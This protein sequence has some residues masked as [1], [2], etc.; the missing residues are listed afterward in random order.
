M[1]QLCIQIFFLVHI[2]T[3][4]YDICRV[5]LKDYLRSISFC[6]KNHKMTIFFF[7]LFTSFFLRFQRVHTCFCL[8]VTTRNTCLVFEFSNLV[9]ISFLFQCLFPD[10]DIFFNVAILN[11]IVAEF[12]PA[13]T[14]DPVEHLGI[15][16]ICSQYGDL[17][18]VI[19]KI[20]HQILRNCPLKQTFSLNGGPPL[21][22]TNQKGICL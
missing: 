20:Y 8:Y 18:L 1:K 10:L 6:M 12:P 21:D 19:C 11:K 4:S 7:F 15:V 16:G 13:T 9:F 17:F 3:Q 5:E 22:F 2:T 14:T